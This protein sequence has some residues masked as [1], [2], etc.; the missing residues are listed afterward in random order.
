M[1]RV[2]QR[3]ILSFAVALA[4]VGVLSVM[5][6]V[7]KSLVI[8]LGI[9][10]VSVWRSLLG[11][12]LGAA[13]Y[14]PRRGDWPSRRTLRLHVARGVIISAM[15]VAFFWGLARTPIAQAIALTFIAPLIALFLSALF[16]GEKVG[17]RIVLASLVAFGGVAMILA[18]QAQADLGQDALLG[19]A[20]ILFS[21]LC[22]AVNIVLMRAQAMAARPPEITFFQNATIAGVMLL[23]IPVFGGVDLPS[24]YWL[25]LIVASLMSTAGV[26]LFAFAYARGEANY[27][28]VTEYSAFIWAAALGWFFFG[29][30]VSPVTLA[31]AVLIVG[32]CLIA[33]RQGKA[34]AT[35]P[36]IEAVA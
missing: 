6:A 8:A 18:G 10:V 33:A 35:E 12:L 29:E 25:P 27:L 17:S 24:G 26:L 9:Y 11:A 21:A 13:I 28:S 30:P 36:E 1:N 22:Y 19:S 4:A 16:L 20:A 31:G 23:S 14:L 5:D 32:G 2:E 3:P 34:A 7:M 15:G